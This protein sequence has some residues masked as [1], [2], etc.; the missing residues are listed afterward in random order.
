MSLDDGFMCHGFRGSP[1][2]PRRQRAG[3]PPADPRDSGCLC[4]ACGRRYRVDVVVA[5]ALWSKIRPAQASGPGGG[6][7][8][9]GCI[10]DAIERLQRVSD[11][12]AAFRLEAM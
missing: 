5:D 6:R 4:H 11:G 8:C 9:G 2:T 10:L 7:L 3:T 1:E 12:F